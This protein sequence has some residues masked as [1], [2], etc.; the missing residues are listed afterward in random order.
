M[1]KFHA[2]VK[3]KSGGVTDQAEVIGLRVAR[4]LVKENKLLKPMLRKEGLL[5]CDARIGE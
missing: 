1:G 2:A 5:T 4:A 3:V